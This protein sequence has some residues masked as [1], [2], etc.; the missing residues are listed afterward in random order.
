MDLI[1]NGGLIG[2]VALMVLAAWIQSRKRAKARA[3]ATEYVVEQL[4]RD[5]QDRQALS[6]GGPAAVEAPN[7]AML[8]LESSQADE[9]AAMRDEIASLV[10]RQPEDVAQLL[11]G[12]LVERGA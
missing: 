3:Q 8:A 4:R 9:T 1:R 10:E 6:A 11:R 5:A 2:L 12:W 7:P